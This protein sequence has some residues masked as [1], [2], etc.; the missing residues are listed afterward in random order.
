MHRGRT[1]LV[2]L[3]IAASCGSSVA[4]AA[5][6]L[7]TPG[8]DVLRGTNHAD[9]LY[10]GAGNDKLFGRGGNDRLYGGSGN[11]LL[12]ADTGGDRLY[13]GRGADTLLGGA[14]RD[15]IYAATKRD[16]T[17]TIVAGAGNDRIY[18]RDGSPDDISCGPGVD[19]V[20]AD[21]GDRVADDCERVRRGG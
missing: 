5:T 3:L 9:R 8:D 19:F 18:A 15:R 6:R 17:D 20:S 14:G 2:L 4:L 7:G 16:A 12:A 21:A 10:G 11:D 1:L 13:A